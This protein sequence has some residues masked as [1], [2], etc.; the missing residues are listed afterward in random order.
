MT[1]NYMIAALKR[2]FEEFWE[3]SEGEPWKRE[4][5]ELA[6]QRGFIA[7]ARCVINRLQEE[8]DEAKGN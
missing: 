3:A 6:F 7:G 5:N 4:E 1:R 8:E 2:D